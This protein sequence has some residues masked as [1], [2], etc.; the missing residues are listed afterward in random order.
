MGSVGIAQVSQGHLLEEPAEAIAVAKKEINDFGSVSFERMPVGEYRMI[1]DLQYDH[2]VTPF[3][4]W[5]A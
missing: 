4:S 5:R 2:P 3:K 1:D